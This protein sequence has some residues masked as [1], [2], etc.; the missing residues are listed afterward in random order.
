MCVCGGG[1]SRTFEQG[2]PGVRG[3]VMWISRVKVLQAE[4]TKD[5]IVVKQEADWLI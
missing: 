1:T 4:D 3:L 2:L 5:L